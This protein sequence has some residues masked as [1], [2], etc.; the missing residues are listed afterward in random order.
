M[1]DPLNI[2][3]VYSR[4]PTKK[5]ISKLKTFL[6]KHLINFRPVIIEMPVEIRELWKPNMAE[7]D[8]AKVFKWIWSQT[9]VRGVIIVKGNDQATYELVSFLG[10]NK[11]RIFLY[12]KRNKKGAPEFGDI[13]KPSIGF[14]NL[15]RSLK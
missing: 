12:P 3:W 5:Q 10:L 15:L 4:G 7:E 1:K 2:L 11:D 9:E 13:K 8:R 6:K 14:I